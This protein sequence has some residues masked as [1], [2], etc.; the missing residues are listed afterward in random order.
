MASMIVAGATGAIGRT[1]VQYAIQQSWINRVVALTREKNITTSNYENLFGIT[2]VGDAGDTH[3]GTENNTRNERKGCLPSPGTISVTPAEAAKINPIAID[4]EAFTQLWATTRN[5]GSAAATAVTDP[6]E[7]YKHIFSGHMYAAMCLGTTRKDAGSAEGFM[8]C[9]YDY[10]MAF[11]EA[12]LMYSAP[13]GLAPDTIFMRHIGDKG[14]SKH[15][16]VQ[17]GVGADENAAQSSRTLRVLCQVSSSGACSSSWFL[18][19]KTKGIADDS[20]V[21]RVYAHNKH[22]TATD[23]PP[24][25]NLVLLRPGP[26]DRHGKTRG[27]ERF[28]KLIVSSLPVETCG[29]AIISACKH[30][31][32]QKSA[33]Q[34]ADDTEATDEQKTWMGKPYMATKLLHKAGM[35]L[36]EPLSFIYEANNSAIKEMASRLAT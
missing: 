1:V 31:P 20:T 32:A 23:T 36:N 19:L 7:Q 17:Q 14:L 22:I 30:L 2:I 34:A 33:R 18:Y 11:T 35:P 6:M 12:L 13:A 26:L 15:A 25:V 27:N 3:N 9:D 28:I 8:R 4:W 29:A 16:H 21:E 5:S 10:V 24:S